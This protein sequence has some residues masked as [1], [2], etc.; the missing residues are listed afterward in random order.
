[1][2]TW[3]RRLGHTGTHKIR[4]MLRTGQL[5]RIQ[6]TVP[7]IEIILEEQHIHPFP[8][9]ISTAIRP[10]DVI[11]SDV[12]GPLPHSHSGGCYLVTFV[13]ELTRY[14]TNFALIRCAGFSALGKFSSSKGPIYYRFDLCNSM[15]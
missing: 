4:S 13:D 12:V 3:H 6:N 5:P 9:S 2:D 14:V 7:C 10:G 8:G 1:V 11:H 15:Q